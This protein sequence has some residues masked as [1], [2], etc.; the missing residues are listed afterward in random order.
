MTLGKLPPLCN[1]ESKDRGVRSIEPILCACLCQPLIASACARLEFKCLHMR[2]ALRTVTCQGW[3]AGESEVPLS[4]SLS[5]MGIT[6]A[7]DF[8]KLFYDFYV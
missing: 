3:V 7:S 8:L 4:V 2:P 5:T 6:G 1:S